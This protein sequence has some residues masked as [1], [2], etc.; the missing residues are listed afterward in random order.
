M[1]TQEKS[2]WPR[3]PPRGANSKGC[4]VKCISSHEP[5]LYAQ[6]VIK[7]PL[8]MHRLICDFYLEREM[9]SMISFCFHLCRLFPHT[10][11][12]PSPRPNRHTVL[13]AT[14]NV[15]NMV[16][17][18]YYSGVYGCERGSMFGACNSYHQN[19]QSKKISNDQELIQS[20]PI[21]CPQNQKGNN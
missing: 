10:P 20:D 18:R 13:Q 4:A 6:L 2:E 1:R 12:P 17:V 11:P 14:K 9:K 3:T 15:M 19:Q 8:H 7:C 16:H 5:S 21:S